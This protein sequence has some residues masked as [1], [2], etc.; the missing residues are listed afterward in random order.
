MTKR[1]SITTCRH[2]LAIAHWTPA[3]GIPLTLGG[4]E[5]IITDVVV[6]EGRWYS[7]EQRLSRGEQEQLTQRVRAII[8]RH[9]NG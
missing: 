5:R 3:G 4:E 6:R 1:I 8:E 2:A 7:Q 9:R